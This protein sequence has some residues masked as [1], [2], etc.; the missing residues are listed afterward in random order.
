MTVHIYTDG[1]CIDGNGGWAA[2][3]IRETEGKEERSGYVPNTTNN[4][5]EMA[6]VLNG[7]RGARL[8]EPVT[9][10]TDSKL[11]IGWLDKHWKCNY[12]H[13]R[14]IRAAIT[15]EIKRKRLDVRY[16]KVNGHAGHEWNELAD[17]LAREAAESPDESTLSIAYKKSQDLTDYLRQAVEDEQDT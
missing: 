10:Y 3:L 4:A 2:V 1:S 16:V 5:M 6:A 7:L 17:A 8:D 13:I 15:Q 11:V 9:V 12:D 14:I